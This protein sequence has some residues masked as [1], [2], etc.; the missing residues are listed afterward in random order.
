MAVIEKYLI[1]H[2]SKITCV[3]SDITKLLFFQPPTCLILYF[4]LFWENL[5]HPSIYFI[6]V[7]WSQYLLEMQRVKYNHLLGKKSLRITLMPTRL[8]APNI[9]HFGLSWLLDH[10]KTAF[11][12]GSGRS[13]FLPPNSKPKIKE[14][15]HWRPTSERQSNWRCKKQR[16]RL[17]YN[18]LSIV[19]NKI[20]SGKCCIYTHQILQPSCHPCVYQ[21]T[22]LV[23]IPWGVAMVFDRIALQNHTHN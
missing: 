19:S 2:W 17:R 16:F 15:R 10:L 8:T 21:I 23:V 7:N 22:D 11:H 1:L 5:R 18:E 9:A 20:D 6:S 14:I 13:I 4:D 12:H 3:S